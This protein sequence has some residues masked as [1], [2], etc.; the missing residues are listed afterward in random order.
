MVFS[1]VFEAATGTTDWQEKRSPLESTENADD[2]EKKQ[3]QTRRDNAWRLNDSAMMQAQTRGLHISQ[4]SVKNAKTAN[5]TLRSQ[6]VVIARGGGVTL[7]LW[8]VH[9]NLA[10]ESTSCSLTDKLLED[11]F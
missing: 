1:G 5:P 10:G 9:V 3:Q 7:E 8:R 11:L 4:K 2:A 6:V